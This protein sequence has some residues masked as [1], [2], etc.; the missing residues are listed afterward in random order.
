MKRASALALALAFV[1]GSAG[2]QSLDWSTVVPQVMPSV[3]NVSVIAKPHDMGRHD[4]LWLIPGVQSNLATDLFT[5]VRAW[6]YDWKKSDAE[7]TWNTIGAGFVFGDGRH[8]LTAAHVLANA[9]QQR[10]KIADG[11]W[12]SAQVVGLDEAADVAVMEIAGPAGRPIA[13]NASAPRQGEAIMAIGAPQGLGF[14]V[15]VGVVSRWSVDTFF[16]ADRFLQIAAPITGG[17]SGGVVVNARGEA[18]GIVSYGGSAFTQ[19]V[20]I[21]RALRVAD[22]LLSHQAC[23]SPQRCR[24][25]SG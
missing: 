13:I 6:A 24:Q 25:F 14:S 1:T 22:L 17:N 2:A 18:V 3:V 10:V 20:P 9:S 15:S 7:R 4:R 11:E 19:T 23:S 16:K 12:R 8:V 21:D 5:R